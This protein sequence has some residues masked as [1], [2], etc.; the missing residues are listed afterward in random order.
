MA[1][2][3]ALL[4]TA[5]AQ[6]SSDLHLTTAAPPRIRAR[7]ELDPVPG[8]AP[9]SGPEIDDAIRELLTPAEQTEFDEWRD[10]EIT[11]GLPG[12][13]RFRV[14]YFATVQ[15][16]AAVFRLVP[17]TALGLETLSLPPAFDSLLVRRSGLVL[18]SAPAG[19]GRS[20][21]CA[22]IVDRIAATTS[23]M[24]VSIEDVVE[25][26]HAKKLGVVLQ[27][28][29]GRDAPGWSDAIAAAL[30]LDAEVLVVGDL[31]DAATT[32]LA[33]RAAEG[34]RLVIAAPA[35][36]GA[37]RTLERLVEQF[38]A[39]E[40]GELRSLLADNLLGVLSQLLVRR[41]E[42]GGRVAAHELLLASPDLASSLRDGEIREIGA[43]LDAGKSSGMLSLDDS[44]EKLLR[45][46]AIGVEEAHRKATDKGRFAAMLPSSAAG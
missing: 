17:E 3:D 4:R 41:K 31:P 42:G 26:L 20:T 11:Y 40:Q 44:L 2:I 43:I 37:V 14:S 7:G 22:S 28:E 6:G 36:P 38:P 15:G 8:F 23:R 21:L 27:R 35:V 39:V 16:P 1:K 12:V 5:R 13:A 30:R 10:V 45:A 25:V 18:V 24:V 29:V 32:R 46:D 33:L 34:G 19:S 9:M